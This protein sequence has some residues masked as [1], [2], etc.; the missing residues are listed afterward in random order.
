[1]A[2]RYAESDGGMWM[3][4]LTST[5]GVVYSVDTRKTMRIPGETATVLRF[6]ESASGKEAAP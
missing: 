4:N 3:L 5:H 2:G 1:M 6:A